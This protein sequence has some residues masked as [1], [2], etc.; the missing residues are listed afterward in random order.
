MGGITDFTRFLQN[1][2]CCDFK[3]TLLLQRLFT[4]KN[5]FKREMVG[6]VQAE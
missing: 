4:C 1:T 5:E 6:G 2:E 3:S